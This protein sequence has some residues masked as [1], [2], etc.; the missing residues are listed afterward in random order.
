M[1][2]PTPGGPSLTE[3]IRAGDLDAIAGFRD[4]HLEQIRGYCEVV[5]AP[6]RVQEA[7][8]SVFLEFVGRVRV[9]DA[10]LGGEAALDGDAPL[11]KLLL[12]ATRSA[13]AARFERWP[14]SRPPP[15]SDDE[16]AICA[17][18]PELLAAKANGELRGDGVAVREHVAG[19][20]TCSTTTAR[21]QR[22]ERAFAR[23]TGWEL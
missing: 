7:C 17:A 6:D 18:M 2:P 1:S 3:L 11:G 12:Q 19:C 21:L 9:S 8:D 23:A 10:A 16:D 14:A 4:A 22:A 5:C 15:R 13:S 20:P